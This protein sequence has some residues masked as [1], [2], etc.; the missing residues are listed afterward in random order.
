MRVSSAR[1]DITK[2]TPG[3]IDTS[4][5]QLI[6]RRVRPTLSGY[7]ICGIDAL[8]ITTFSFRRFAAHSGTAESNKMAACTVLPKKLLTRVELADRF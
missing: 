6:R 7:Q 2:R 4:S 3:D 5:K 1:R 8:A